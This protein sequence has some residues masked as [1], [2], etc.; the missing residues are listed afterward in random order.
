MADLLVVH[1]LRLKA[2]AISQ[3]MA[4][5]EAKIAECRRD[6]SAVLATI[7]MF[8]QGG[9]PEGLPPYIDLKR[10]FRRGELLTSW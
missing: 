8:E 7:A 5:Y 6:L 3:T 2:D 10:V 9:D 1:T 4:A